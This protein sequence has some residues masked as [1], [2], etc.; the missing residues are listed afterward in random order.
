MP[1]RIR[2]ALLAAAASIAVPAV[3][4]LTAAPAQAHN[5]LLSSSP[6]ER[7]QL[8][9]LPRVVELTFAETAD[10]R[11][12]KIAATG[13]DGRSVAAGTPTVSG[14]VVRQPLSPGAASGAY[15]VAYRVVSKDGHP[16]QG[17]VTFTATLAAGSTSPTASPSST[18]PGVGTADQPTRKVAKVEK[19]SRG[20]LLYLVG[21]L[22]TLALIGVALVMRSRAS[23]TG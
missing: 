13:P 19:D 7:A 22:G 5:E 15:T 12:V 8:T 1:S 21:S 14:T 23:R 3:L 18:E 11:F 17:S 10:P 16:V 9:A 2:A 6:A 20:W 4:A